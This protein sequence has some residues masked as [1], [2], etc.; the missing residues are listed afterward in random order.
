M[1]EKTKPL[2]IVLITLAVLLLGTILGA[3]I[4]EKNKPPIDQKTHCPIGSKPPVEMV[5]L[6]TSDPWITGQIEFG[7]KGVTKIIKGSKAGSRFILSSVQKSI[8]PYESLKMPLHQCLPTIPGKHN[9]IEQGGR[10][11]EMKYREFDSNLQKVITKITGQKDSNH[12]S[13]IFETIAATSVTLEDLDY[14]EAKV[15]AFSNMIQNSAWF[16]QLPDGKHMSL[17]ELQKS[18]LYEVLAPEFKNVTIKIVCMVNAKSGPLQTKAHRQFW[19]KA[20]KGMG[21]TKVEW[22]TRRR[23]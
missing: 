7:K 1:E 13:P 23:F 15:T 6:D 12:P 17:E 5:L 4:K 19:E 22:E 18:D 8:S 3:G 16:S 20:L 11:A 9:P 2:N 14:H 10:D 21:F